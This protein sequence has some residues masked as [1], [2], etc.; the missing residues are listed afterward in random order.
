M[1]RYS[2]YILI[3][4]I[5]IQNWKHSACIKK[6]KRDVAISLCYNFRTITS[7]VKKSIG[8]FYCPFP[9]PPFVASLFQVR[10]CVLLT[11]LVELNF[12]ELLDSTLTKVVIGYITRELYITSFVVNN[13]LLVIITS[14]F[15][16]NSKFFLTKM[17][18]K[19]RYITAKLV[20]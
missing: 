16:K 1:Q 3:R 5:S 7:W 9:F 14:F 20:I 10:P 18:F 17:T 15:D 13:E 6:L 8:C 2:F 4:H 11:Q 12:R 19:T